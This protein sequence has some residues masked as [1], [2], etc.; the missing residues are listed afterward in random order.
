MLVTLP[1]GLDDGVVQWRGRIAFPCDLSGDALI[2]LRRQSWIDQNGLFRLTQHVD[3]SGGNHLTMRIDGALARR[4]RK[5]AD[6]GNPA[7]ADSHVSGIP[8]RTRPIDN[9]AIGDDNIEGLR[10]AIACRAK[11]PNRKQGRRKN[12]EQLSQVHT[13]LSMEASCAS[14]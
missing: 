7:C 10:E 1:I 3:K 14:T 4:L 8:G 12:R 5:I 13:T 9:V 2:N 6:G 11:H